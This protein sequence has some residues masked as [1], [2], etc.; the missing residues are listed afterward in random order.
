MFFSIPLKEQKNAAFYKVSQA[1]K[2]LPISFNVIEAE[3][4]GA[5]NDDAVSDNLEIEENKKDV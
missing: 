2:L 1:N 5:F 4:A 3:S